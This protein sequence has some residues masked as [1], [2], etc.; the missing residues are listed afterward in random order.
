MTSVKRGFTI[1]ELSLA[2]AFVALLLIAV[3]ILTINISQLYTKGT[4]IKDVNTTGRA[5][6]N[7]MKRTVNSSTAI[8]KTAV[9]YIW[10]SSGQRKNGAFCLGHY[11]YV[12]NSTNSVATKAQPRLAKVPDQTRAKCA[13]NGSSQLSSAAEQSTAKYLIG[14]NSD[15]V[16]SDFNVVLT[17]KESNQQLYTVTFVLGTLTGAASGAINSASCKVPT[18]K[19]SNNDYCAINRFSLTMRAV[20]GKSE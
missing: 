1:I 12:W 7:D 13:A 5:I 11:S 19:D 6:A 10:P 14:D 3:A 20:C 15:L 16:V 4:T 8:D 2:M 18:D 17:K 9:K